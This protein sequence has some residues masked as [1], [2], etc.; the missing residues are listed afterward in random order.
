MNTPLPRRQP[1]QVALDLATL[2]HLSNGRVIFGAGLGIPQDFTKFDLSSDEKVRAAQLDEGLEIIN[3][4]WSGTS[5]S[6]K[7]KYYTINDV[8]LP[9]I[10]IQKP[11][12][13]ILI[14]AWWPYKVGLKRGARWDGIMPAWESP[15]MILE[16]DLREMIDYYHKNADSNG[17]VIVPYNGDI[18]HEFIELCENVGVTWLLA[19]GLREKDKINLDIDKIKEGPPSI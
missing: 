5:V 17:D 18:S 11:R 14:A 9:I 13:P 19:C 6:Y 15:E 2:D 7:G 16:E 10:P 12:I 8:E 4:L 3:N 1:W